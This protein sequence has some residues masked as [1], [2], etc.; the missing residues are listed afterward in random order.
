MV[1]YLDSALPGSEPFIRV[2]IDKVMMMREDNCCDINS[3]PVKFIHDFYVLVAMKV[4]EAN[5]LL[6]LCHSV[7]EGLTLGTEKCVR[8][9]DRMYL[10]NRK[11]SVVIKLRES[12]KNAL[13]PFGE[14]K[15][16]TSYLSLTSAYNLKPIYAVNGDTKRRFFTGPIQVERDG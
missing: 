3:S 2:F 1:N 13:A 10:K 11:E 12:M 15:Y 14:S 16:L 7:K 4:F 8:D 6:V 5:N 9:E